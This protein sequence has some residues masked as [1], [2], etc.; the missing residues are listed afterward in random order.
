MNIFRFKIVADFKDAVSKLVGRRSALDSALKETAAVEGR[1]LL[2]LT[3]QQAPKRTFRFVNAH[4][5]RVQ[6]LNIRILAPEPLATY[7]RKGTRRH[8]ITATAP[9][10]TLR[11]SVQGQVFYRRR[12][13][14]PGTRPNDY[15][16]RAY[17]NFRTGYVAAHGETVRRLY[18]A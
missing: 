3:Q 5:L 15:I 6:A 9:G 14:H 10:S 17:R 1:R 18:V 16:E 13:M 4:Q 7:I 2:R 8:P 11:F 12:V